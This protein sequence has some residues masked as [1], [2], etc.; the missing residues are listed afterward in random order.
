MNEKIGTIV[1]AVKGEL[2][3]VNNVDGLCY[4][5][6]NNIC[7]DLEQQGIMASVFNIRDMADV[8]YDHYFVLAYDD[9]YFL[10]DLT[11]NQFKNIENSELRFFDEWPATVLLKDNEE[12]AVKL[13]NDGY[14]I[15][16]DEDLYSYLSSFNSE[17]IGLFTLDDVLEVRG[18]VR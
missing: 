3:A 12:L 16:S 1:N 17:F 11:F 9:N 13:L 14:S 2:S 5:A 18:N 15:I 6:S 8:S 7:F 10:I 4:Y